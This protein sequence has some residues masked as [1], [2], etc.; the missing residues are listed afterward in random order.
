MNSS[1]HSKIPKAVS[2]RRA[3]RMIICSEAS[4][5]ELAL[6]EVK[7]KAPAVFMVPRFLTG[8]KNTRIR[9]FLNSQELSED[10]CPVIRGDVK[11]TGLETS[12]WLSW[13]CSLEGVLILL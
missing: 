11:G 5:P 2:V 1:P 7:G 10:H 8:L 9:G 6:F 4:V 12:H 3:P 13:K